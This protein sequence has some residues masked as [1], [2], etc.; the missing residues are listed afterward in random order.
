MSPASP[1]LQGDSLPLSHQ[2]S[3]PKKLLLPNELEAV[4]CRDLSH[5]VFYSSGIMTINFPIPL[6]A[7][8]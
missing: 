3:Q 1:A 5:T 6:S 7:E 4:L 2:G 8:S